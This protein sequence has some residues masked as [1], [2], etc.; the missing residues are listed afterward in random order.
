MFFVN[1]IR[2]FK[3]AFQGFLRNFWLSFVC[4]TTITSAFILI[5]ILGGVGIISN[6]AIDSIKS[7]I[8]V[9]VYI[10]NEATE[11]QIFA[12]KDELS[13][14]NGIKSIEYISKAEALNN[15][16]TKHSNNTVLI[17]S[18]NELD[19]NPIGASLII[20]ADDAKNYNYI[21]EY[22]KSF[23]YSNLIEDTDYTDNQTI[24]N[25]INSFNVSISNVVLFIG[26]FFGFVS[27]ITVL[28]T[29]R[30]TIYSR[31]REIEIMR[32]LGASWSFIKVP[33]LLEAGFYLIFG[34]LL[35][36]G[37][38]YA[39]LLFIAPY[40]NIFFSYAQFDIVS[41]VTAGSK[42]T[43]FIEFIVGFVVT[44]FASMISIKKY[45]KV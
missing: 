40:V 10:K 30:I 18:L 20:K 17:N 2:L 39:I 14:L 28:N 37:I 22:M 8:D 11:D 21:L 9:S 6:N 23:K 4:I 26:L 25:K 42:M 45:A 32:F 36:I 33:F 27:A 31:R 44:M 13:G 43:V 19:T 7:K 5:D 34:W 16:K 41:L 35:S 12:I 24:I 15:F 3:Y 29:L 1:C 38:Y